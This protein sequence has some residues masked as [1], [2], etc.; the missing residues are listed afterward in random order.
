[1]GNRRATPGYQGQR[2]GMR[3]IERL[4]TMRHMCERRGRDLYSGMPLPR[5]AWQR[6]QN[7]IPGA[8]DP[9]ELGNRRAILGYHGRRSGMRESEAHVRKKDVSLVVTHATSTKR[10]TTRPQWN[11]WCTRP[12]GVTWGIDAQLREIRSSGVACVRVR[13]CAL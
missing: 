11:S 10:M 12:W 5:N 2:S 6:G 9:G 8:P 4:C 13:G 7:G 1:M 3:E